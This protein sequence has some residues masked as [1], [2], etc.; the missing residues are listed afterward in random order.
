MPGSPFRVKILGDGTMK[1]PT[2]MMVFTP[3]PRPPQDLAAFEEIDDEEDEGAGG[4]G[5][6]HSNQ[7]PITS[8]PSVLKSAEDAERYTPIPA[9]FQQAP[10]NFAISPHPKNERAVTIG[11]APLRPGTRVRSNRTGKRRPAGASGRINGQVTVSVANPNKSKLK[12][13]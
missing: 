9:T 2:E 1:L 4:G 8:T 6:S 13:K 12:R 10:Q 7:N 5:I 11:H 3:T